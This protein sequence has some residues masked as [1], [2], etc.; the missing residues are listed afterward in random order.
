MVR[1]K[2]TV[3]KSS[4]PTYEANVGVEQEWRIDN[5]VAGSANKIVKFIRNG[6]IATALTCVVVFIFYEAFNLV[7]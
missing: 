5:D 6:I 7:G 3:G 4:T 1:M 2:Y